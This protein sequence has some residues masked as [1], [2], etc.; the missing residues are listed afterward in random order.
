MEQKP[1]LLVGRGLASSGAWT[2]W[3]PGLA[4]PCA[5]VM[6]IAQVRA[7]WGV[8]VGVCWASGSGAGALEGPAG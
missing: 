4:V 5:S 3:F 2:Y 7:L 8:K 1:E 6:D